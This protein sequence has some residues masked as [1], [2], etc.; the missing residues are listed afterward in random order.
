MKLSE[1]VFDGGISRQEDRIEKHKV[2]SA[3]VIQAS[4]RIEE[5]AEK[6]A[7]RTIVEV[8]KVFPDDATVTQAETTAA[9]EAARAICCLL[10]TGQIIFDLDRKFD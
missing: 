1:H 2:G 6:M 4:G 9:V 7:W 10:Q 5:A 8:A 3:C